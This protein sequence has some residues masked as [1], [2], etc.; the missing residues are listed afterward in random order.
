M[1]VAAAGY[2]L[3][4]PLDRR[5][6]LLDTPDDG[7]SFYYSQPFVAELVPKFDHSNR[8]SLIIFASFEDG[9][10][11][12]LGN[13]KRASGGAGQSLLKIR[14]LKPLARPVTFEELKNGVPARLAQHLT[15]VLSDG[16]LLPQKRLVPWLIKSSNSML[17]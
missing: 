17:R 5:D 1:N 12:H 10:I 16:G 2:I 14:D 8:A 4:V 9:K 3:R 11:T 13:C 7:Y 15:R 6:L